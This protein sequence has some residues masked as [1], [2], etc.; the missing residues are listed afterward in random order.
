MIEVSQHTL[1]VVQEASLILA[2]IAVGLQS[3]WS[4]LVYALYRPLLILRGIAAVNVLV[5][6]TAVTL[7]SILALDPVVKAGIIL[8]AVSP[9]SPIVP[10]NMLKAGA[11][12][13]F[14]TGLCVVLVLLSILIVPLTLALLS[15][16]FPADVRFSPIAAAELAISSILLP[17]LIGLVH[18]ALFPT[19]AWKAAKIAQTLSGAGLMLYMLVTTATLWDSMVALLGD[20]GLLAIVLTIG[21][22]LLAGHILGGPGSNDR[23]A[24]SAAAAIRHPGLAG[25]IIAANF[26]D[27]RIGS[28]TMIFL[29]TSFVMT[30]IY[31]RAAK[32]RRPAPFPAHHAK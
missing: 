31:F 2:V 22:G 27:P 6:L 13:S 4:D 19:F 3:R 26:T 5:P 18:N 28:V 1:S 20:G 10:G 24:L 25:A 14:T 30:S 17:L 11:T 32:K 23:K 21:T 12:S 15:Q 16:A 9:L 29:L 7:V 8:M